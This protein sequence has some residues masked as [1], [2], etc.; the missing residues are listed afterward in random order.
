MGDIPLLKPG[1]RL[2]GP[3]YL[4]M[5]GAPGSVEEPQLINWWVEVAE[6]RHVMLKAKHRDGR[7]QCV[8]SIVPSRSGS[9]TMTL[10]ALIDLPLC[11][12]F[13]VAIKQA[14]SIT[15][16]GVA[17]HTVSASTEPTDRGDPA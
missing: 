2:A 3:E 17:D 5:S 6:N 8:V 9:L 10:P 7:V 11:E 15:I 16:E 12:A 1:A 4:M 13:G 14:V